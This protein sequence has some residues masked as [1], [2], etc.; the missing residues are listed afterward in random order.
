MQTLSNRMD[1][2][3]RY[4]TLFLMK[5]SRMWFFLRQSPVPRTLPLKVGTVFFVVKPLLA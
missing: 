4:S 2:L 3:A 1:K 5:F